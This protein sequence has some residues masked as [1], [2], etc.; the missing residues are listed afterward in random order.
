MEQYQACV[1]WFGRQIT[2]KIVFERRIGRW[3]NAIVYLRCGESQCVGWATSHFDHVFALKCCDC[4]WSRDC[5][6]SSIAKLTFVVITCFCWVR[7]KWNF[8]RILLP[9]ESDDSDDF[10]NFS[11]FR[12]HPK[13]KLDP[14]H[15]MQHNVMIRLQSIRFWFLAMRPLSSVFVRDQR[16]RDLADGS[17]PVKWVTDDKRC[18]LFEFLL[19]I[20]IGLPC[21]KC[22]RSQSGSA[23]RRTIGKK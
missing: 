3:T 22:R 5:S 9:L 14:C 15:R 4:T 21:P 10:E 6:Y 16:F 1:Q 8:V 2:H 11:F 12:N 18:F 13:C 17:R 7:N 19:Q 23:Q 20:C